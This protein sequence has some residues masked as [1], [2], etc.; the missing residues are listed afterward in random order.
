M[1]SKLLAAHK[2]NLTQTLWHN[3][4]KARMVCIIFNSIIPR[5]CN[6]RNISRLSSYSR[7]QEIT[8]EQVSEMYS[9]N[10]LL[11]ASIEREKCWKTKKIEE[12]EEDE[13]EEEEE[14]CEG[15]LRWS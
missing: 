13:E 6:K 15:I 9:K 10:R 4:A 14:R 11:C 5:D 8:N 1:H 3:K 7:A 2:H 12:E